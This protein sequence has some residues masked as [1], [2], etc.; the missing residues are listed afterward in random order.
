MPT[1]ELLNHPRGVVELRLNRPEA[2]NAVSVELARDMDRLTTQ[3]AAD[4]GARVVVVSAAGDSAFCAGADL[5]E[6]HGMSDAELIATRPVSRRAYNSLLELPIPTIA[7]VHGHALGGGFELAL[8]CDLIVVA[9]QA[10]LGLPEVSRGIIPGGGGT[11]LV[12]RRVGWSRAAMVIFTGKRL[13]ARQAHELGLVDEL[14]PTGQ[15]LDRALE[16]AH[17]IARNSPTALRQA[18]RAMRRG[19]G[20]D[21]PAALDV[22]DA[23]WH[24]TALGPDRAE[25]VAA[26]LE[27][28]DPQWSEP[29]L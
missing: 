9:Q 17:S 14:V 22:E 21:L 7:A 11:Q 25:G 1:I 27:K 2:L 16:L 20:L 10:M 15:A 29:R 26:F 12:T 13:D 3:I 28:R 19:A 23:C 6:R 8:S 5:K 4:P 18:K 24:A